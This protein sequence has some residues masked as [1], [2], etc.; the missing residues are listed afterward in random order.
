M[1]WHETLINKRLTQKLPQFT[2][3]TTRY[4]RN[5]NNISF[6][7]R[8]KLLNELSNHIRLESSLIFSILIVLVELMI[9]YEVFASYYV[10]IVDCLELKHLFVLILD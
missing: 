4:A 9:A 8:L 7:L 6:I 10:E 1:L 2:F 5:D 3:S